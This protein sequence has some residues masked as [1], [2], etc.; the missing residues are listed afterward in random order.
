[1]TDNDLTWDMGPPSPI[2][3]IRKMQH[4][5]AIEAMVEWFFTN[6]EDPVHRTPWDGGYVFIWGGPHYAQDELER[7]FGRVAS[8]RAIA[9]AVDRIEEDGFEWVPS[10][11]RM[12]PEE[13][14]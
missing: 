5:A 2:P 11:S 8:E 3:D 1:M 13:P 12:Q 9:T 10:G 7:A 6:F 14:A 4:A